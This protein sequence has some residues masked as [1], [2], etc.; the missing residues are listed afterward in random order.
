MMKKWELGD[1]VRSP[2]GERCEVI[3][4]PPLHPGVLLR[5]ESFVITASQSTLVDRGWR[6]IKPKN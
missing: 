4:A 3:Q 1:W 6:I 5:C 2:Q